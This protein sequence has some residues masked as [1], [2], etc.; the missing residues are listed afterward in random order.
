MEL[1]A[2]CSS[3]DPPI[4][5]VETNCSRKS[6]HLRYGDSRGLKGTPIP[7]AN[8]PSLPDLAYGY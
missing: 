2:I 4:S 8:G 3:F 1:S 6:Q 7:P 5:R